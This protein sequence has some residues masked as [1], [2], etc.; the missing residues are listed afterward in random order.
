MGILLRW[1]KV[2]Q[3]Y[4]TGPEELSILGQTSVQLLTL[5]H[6]QQMSEQWQIWPKIDKSQNFFRTSKWNLRASVVTKVKGPMDHWRKTVAN[7]IF[8]QPRLSFAHRCSPDRSSPLPDERW[9]GCWHITVRS[10]TAKQGC[11][12]FCET[13]NRHLEVGWLTVLILHKANIENAEGPRPDMKAASGKP[14]VCAKT[15][16]S[17][18][19]VFVN[20]SYN[21]VI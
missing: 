2:V 6:F 11:A 4:F 12:M 5:E 3:H 15:G 13:L 10:S 16:P 1:G 18:Q 7:M 21:N 14:A 9:Q 20:W 8:L 17:Y 19:W